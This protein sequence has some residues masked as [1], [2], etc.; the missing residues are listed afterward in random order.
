MAPLGLFLSLGLSRSL[1]FHLRFLLFKPNFRQGCFSPH[2]LYFAFFQEQTAV[3]ALG[4]LCWLRPCRAVVIVQTAR[5]RFVTWETNR[6]LVILCFVLACVPSSQFNVAPPFLL[7]PHEFHQVNL[8][9]AFSG[10]SRGNIYAKDTLTRVSCNLGLPT[11][12]FQLSTDG[13][14]ISLKS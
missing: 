7:L 2:G 11:Y 8:C 9:K 12:I 13:F 5:N 14:Q 10:S 3:K 1:S 4:A 6:G